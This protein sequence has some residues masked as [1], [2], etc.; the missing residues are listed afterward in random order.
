MGQ[1]NTLPYGLQQLDRDRSIAAIHFVGVHLQ[2]IC[3]DFL[4]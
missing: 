3:N 4:L 2:G 1:E